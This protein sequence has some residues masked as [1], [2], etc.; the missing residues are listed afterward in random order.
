MV[1]KG[2]RQGGILSPLLFKLYIDDIIN[3]ISNMDVGCK[4]GV[5]RLNILAYAD[6]FVLMASSRSALSKLYEALLEKT[7]VKKLNINK[8]KSQCMIFGKNVRNDLEDG[9]IILNDRFQMVTQYKY[10]GHIIHSSLLDNLDIEYRLNMFY[11]KFNWVFRN[12]RGLSVE[13]FFYLFNAYC[14]PDYGM[15]LWN[16]GIIFNKQNVLAFEIAYSNALKK[17][18]GVPI[19]TSSH[20]VANEQ[21]QFLLN[22]HVLYN[23]TRYFKRVVN[24]TNVLLKSVLFQI[25]EGVLFKSLERRLYDFYEVDF[26]SNDLSILRSRIT[27][28]QR[29]EP[30]T[31]RPLNV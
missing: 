28:V 13:T 21:S 9:V 26:I 1:D 16:L 2:V 22:H 15:S 25:K 20:L 6:D 14:L 29:H 17:M 23:E 8:E 19:N 24:S 7:R 31:G 4:F 5:V 18:R 3:E 11:A 10:L 27:W 12:F 30:V